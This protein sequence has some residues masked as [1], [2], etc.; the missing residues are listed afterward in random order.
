MVGDVGHARRASRCE[1]R[2]ILALIHAKVSAM[3]SV[4]ALTAMHASFSSAWLACCVVTDVD[5]VHGLQPLFPM[6]PHAEAVRL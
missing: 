1:L 2:L 3:L 6:V 5:H 4:H